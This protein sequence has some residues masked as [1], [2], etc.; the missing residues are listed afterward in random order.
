M[1][2]AAR[3]VRYREL[4]A[5]GIVGCTAFAVHIGVVTLLVPHGVRP[6]VANV[7]AFLTAFAVS[8]LGH[9]RWSFP[10]AGRA[11]APALVRFAVVAVSGFALNEAAYAALLAWTPLDYR[12]ALFFVLAGVAALTFFAGRQWAFATRPASAAADGGAD[13]ASDRFSSAPTSNRTETS[14]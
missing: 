3:P 6:L 13:S 1:S 2:V 5:F 11:V 7:V 10:A 14:Y 4:A 9:A 8:F 12:V